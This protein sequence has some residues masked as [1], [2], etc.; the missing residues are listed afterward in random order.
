ML[1]YQLSSN[2]NKLKIDRTKWY[3][4][5][6]EM[7]KSVDIGEFVPL[8][9][10]DPINESNCTNHN[11][12]MNKPIPEIKAKTKT[13]NKSIGSFDK[14]NTTYF[15][16]DVYYILKSDWDISDEVEHYIEYFLKK[17]QQ[18]YSILTWK[19]IVDSLSGWLCDMYFKDIENI[20][21]KYFNTKFKQHSLYH[22]T[23]ENVLIHR[24]QEVGLISHAEE[25]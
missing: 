18:K 9:Q 3:R 13:E 17:K 1:I 22:S 6:Y 2:Y 8:V 14:Q 10:N 7:L 4:I 11:V 25:C 23:L 5:D 20:V 19:D 16:N 21:D 12:N 15:F 24:M